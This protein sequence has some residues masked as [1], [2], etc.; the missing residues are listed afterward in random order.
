MMV[1]ARTHPSSPEGRVMG[2]RFRFRYSLMFMALLSPLPLNKGRGWGW[3]WVG[4]RERDADLVVSGVPVHD[5]GRVVG[6]HPFPVREA[7]VRVLALGRA[8]RD[9]VPGRRAE[10]RSE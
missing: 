8:D 6:Q 10:H 9:D 3:G 5:E 2:F 4:L 7:R 1:G